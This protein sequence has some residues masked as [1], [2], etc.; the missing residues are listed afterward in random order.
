MSLIERQHEM[1]IDLLI[2]C[3]DFQVMM[4]G[5]DVGGR[6]SLTDEQMCYCEEGLTDRQIDRQ[7]DMKIYVLTDR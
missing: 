7:T 1:K 2:C 6:C 5:E 3:G 4:Q